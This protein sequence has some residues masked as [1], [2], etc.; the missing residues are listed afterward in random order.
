MNELSTATD[1]DSEQLVQRLADIEILY[2]LSFQPMTLNNLVD[3]LR[4]TF[5]LPSARGTIG[6]ILANL[7]AE[8]LVSVFRKSESQNRYSADDLYG[9]SPVGLK[10]LR[11]DI[12]SLSEIALT[13][14]LG[15]SQ[16]LMRG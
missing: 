10:L 3:S 7:E 6:E 1:P 8:G 15:F 16:K 9:I 4:A 12:K 14:Q 13:M 11:G 5:D 2:M